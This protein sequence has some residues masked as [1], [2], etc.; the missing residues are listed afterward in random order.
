MPSLGTLPWAD[1]AD[2]FAWRGL[3]VSLSGRFILASDW[4]EQILPKPSKLAR[5]FPIYHDRDEGPI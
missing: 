5:P 2:P 3:R 1:V 4:T